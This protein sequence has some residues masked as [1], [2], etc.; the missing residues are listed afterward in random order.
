MAL[1]RS[2]PRG[3]MMLL[4]AS[5]LDVWSGVPYPPG[6]LYWT[7]AFMVLV[8]GVIV[9]GVRQFLRGS[10]LADIATTLGMFLL[11]IGAIVYAVAFRGLRTGELVLGW[12]LSAVAIAWFVRR[13]NLLARRPI[14]E[15]E[16]VGHAI[17]RGDWG[18]VMHQHGGAGGDSFARALQQ[19][20][21]LIA[22]TQRATERVLE[23]SSEAAR[24]GH[25]VR[26]GAGRTSAVLEG[27]R[28]GA[29]DAASATG[30]ISAVSAQLIASAGTVHTAATETRTI[31]RAVEDRALAGVQTA[32]AASATISLLAGAARDLAQ[33]MGELLA[34]TDTVA[35]IA[36][37]VSSISDQT[38]LLALNA[39]IEAAR[40]GIH[41]A[42]FVVVADEVGKLASESALS[43]NRIE[44]IVRQMTTR[45]A[46]AQEAALE[47]ERSSAD[48]ERLMHETMDVLR[49][50]EAKLRRTHELA[51]SVVAASARQAELAREL[52]TFASSIVQA[53]HA[54]A[55]SSRDAATVSAQ[56][57]TLTDDLA[58]TANT[59]EETAGSL[60]QVV[61]R[62]GVGSRA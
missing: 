34:A 36:T 29:A 28:L 4:A 25:E 62:F 13:L 49:D 30:Q 23:A 18:A 53:S 9:F 58:Q 55:D 3:A 61:A 22:E 27:V 46:H 17:R 50:I 26:A 52:S 1:V 40:A 47:V 33:R 24:I 56:Q 37:A 32:G 5:P 11:V 57:L 51:E 8:V 31:S 20:A 39:S 10:V 21:G 45:A 12:V 43:L 16:Q 59:L 60:A 19:V 41:G 7:L 48:G 35:E 38:K 15:L 2:R 14:L 54:A 42:G 6:R 44:D